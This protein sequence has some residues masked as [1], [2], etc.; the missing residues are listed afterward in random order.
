MT[1]FSGPRLSVSTQGPSVAT[2]HAKLS[3]RSAFR[4][5]PTHAEFGNNFAPTPVKPPSRTFRNLPFMPRRRQSLLTAAC[6]FGLHAAALAQP[7]ADSVDASAPLDRQL[8]DLRQRQ[9]EL[10][11]ENAR[12][13]ERIDA[14]ETAGPS[15]VGGDLPTTAPRGNATAWGLN[16]GGGGFYVQGEDYRFRLLGYVQA[17]GTLIDGAVDR[18]DEPGDFSIRRA[19]V[20]FLADFY[21]DYEVLVELDGGP[22][23]TPTAPSDFALVE[24]RLNWKLDGDALQL[25]FGKF[26]TPFSRENSRSSRSIDT[27]ER[28]IA[29]NSLFLL[30]AV[31]VQFG[32]MV[33]GRVGPEKKLGYFAGVFNGNGRANDNLSDDN[34]D[35]ELQAK[36]T[37]D[38]SDAWSVGVAA[39]YSREE[40]QTLALADLAFNRFVEV[41]VEDE[42]FGFGAD[43]FWE[44]G[45]WSFRAEGLAFRFETP[46]QGTVGLVGGFIQPAWFMTGDAQGGVQLLVR[47][48]FAHLDADTDDNGDT[49]YSLTLGMNWFVNPNVRVQLGPALTYF[50]GSSAIQGFEGDRTSALLLTQLQFKF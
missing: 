25:R 13:R 35:K 29:L 37:Y 2:P 47:P 28:Y 23:T 22:G 48:E 33:H 32:A 45:P 39:D 27:I 50:D 4:S 16:P 10:E 9:A 49:L 3:V 34:G 40:I 31:D 24:A 8:D 15:A 17:V 36:L 41:A 5:R 14:L 18:P 26:T 44:L 42:R 6:C 38:F 46:D 12:Q 30:P 20:D 7:A 11:A 19:R 43:V 21:D 1:P